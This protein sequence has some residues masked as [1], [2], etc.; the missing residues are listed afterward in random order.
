MWWNMQQEYELELEKALQKKLEKSAGAATNKSGYKQNHM[1][2]FSSIG[3]YRKQYEEVA[4]NNSC[5]I[6]MTGPIITKQE[7]RK[8]T[9]ILMD[10][11]FEEEQNLS[12]WLLLI[13]EQNINSFSDFLGKSMKGLKDCRQEEEKIHRCCVEFMECDLLKAPFYK[14]LLTE[15]ENLFRAYKFA[16]FLSDIDIP[17]PVN[18]LRCDHCSNNYNC[19]VKIEEFENRRLFGESR[20]GGK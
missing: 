19:F 9:I 17:P 2:D 20:N 12:K 5:S 3:S 8:A 16:A 13:I 4:R 14:A 15:R 6:N 18:I 10:C 11:I 7:C 1:F